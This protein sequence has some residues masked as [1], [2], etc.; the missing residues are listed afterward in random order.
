MPCAAGAKVHTQLV[1]SGDGQ[2]QHKH[3]SWFA[4]GLK[5]LQDFEL[6]CGNQNDAWQSR[7][8]VNLKRER[9]C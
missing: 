4:K 6:D 5:T 8:V 1:L 2:A 3:L 9:R 7:K